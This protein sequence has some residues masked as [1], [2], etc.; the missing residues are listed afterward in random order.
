MKQIEQKNGMNK[1]RTSGNFEVMA[2]DDYVC[3]RWFLG[4]WTYYSRSDAIRLVQLGLWS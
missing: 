1:L 4:A 3:C 2:Y